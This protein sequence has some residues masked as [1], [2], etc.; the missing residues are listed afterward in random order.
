VNAVR[1]RNAD[2][3]VVLMIACPL[4]FD[5]FSIQKEP[6]GRIEPNRANAECTVVMVGRLS[7]T[8]DHRHDAIKIRRIKGPQPRKSLHKFCVHSLID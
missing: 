6:M 2:P 1:D 7:A 8:L 4:E 3:G 5:R